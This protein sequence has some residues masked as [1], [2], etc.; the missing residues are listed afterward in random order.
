MWAGHETNSCDHSYDQQRHSHYKLPCDISV[1]SI[2]CRGAIYNFLFI[3][4]AFIPLLS[5]EMQAN[6]N[7]ASSPGR[8]KLA[9]F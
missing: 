7:I 1:L 3:L 5:A 9:N 4:E 6:S 8:M 2:S